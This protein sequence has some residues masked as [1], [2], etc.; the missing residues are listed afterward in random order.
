MLR[1]GA[2]GGFGGVFGWR[3]APRLGVRGWITCW[4]L[5]HCAIHCSL[6][7]LVIRE[8]LWFIGYWNSPCFGTK[9]T[10]Y[11]HR[12]AHAH[13]HTHKSHSLHTPNLT[14]L[15]KLH[16]SLSNKHNAFRTQICGLLPHRPNLLVPHRLP[17]LLHRNLSHRR[18]SP[19]PRLHRRKQAGRREIPRK[20]FQTACCESAPGPLSSREDDEYEYRGVGDEASECG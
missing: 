11:T 16:F 4:F 7:C 9:S 20:L 6:F 19:A 15:H 18:R 17:N 13:T 2:A 8:E 5:L 12:Q 10:I 3:C 1:R 14:H